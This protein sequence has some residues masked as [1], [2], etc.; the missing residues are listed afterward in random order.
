MDK[1]LV[2]QL[3][4]INTSSSHSNR[5]KAQTSKHKAITQPIASAHS[6]EPIFSSHMISNGSV[7]SHLQERVMK[8]AVLNEHRGSAK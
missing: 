3:M 5:A 6:R 7:P 8:E 4:Q 2:D 1:H